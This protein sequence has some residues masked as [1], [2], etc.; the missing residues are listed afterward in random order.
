MDASISYIVWF[1]AAGKHFSMYE[2]HNKD[3]IKKENRNAVM[4]LDAAEL[5][6]G[7]CAIPGVGV[8]RV[9]VFT[10]S[11]DLNESAREGVELEAAIND[12]AK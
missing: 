4:L 8:K 7:T 3:E 5:K 1:D 9:N 11:Y 10:I 6:N 2:V 12:M